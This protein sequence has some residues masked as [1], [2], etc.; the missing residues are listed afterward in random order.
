LLTDRPSFHRQFSLFEAEM[1]SSEKVPVIQNVSQMI[2]F[3]S[4]AAQPLSLWELV[5]EDVLT[6]TPIPL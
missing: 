4:T 2:D 5:L 1:C 6:L 3:P